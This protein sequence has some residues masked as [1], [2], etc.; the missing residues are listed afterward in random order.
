MNATHTQGPWIAHCA[1]SGAWIE[2]INNMAVIAKWDGE[3]AGRMAMPNARLI[4]A[5]PDLLAALQDCVRVIIAVSPGRR[6]TPQRRA[7]VECARAA[8][9]RAKATNE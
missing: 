9:A 7:V 8:I 2:G 3:S 1:P 4:A 6:M 5:A